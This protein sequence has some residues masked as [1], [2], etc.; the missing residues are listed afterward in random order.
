MPAKRLGDEFGY[1]LV[2]VL[3]S[4]VIMVLAI[5][6]MMAMFDT[7]FRSATTGSNYDTARMLANLKLEQAKNLPFVDVESNFPQAG[8]ATPYDDAAWLTEPGADFTNF[9]YR[10]EKDYMVQP[11]VDPDTGA[12]DPDCNPSGDFFETSGTPTGLIRV[13]VTVGWEGVDDGTPDKTFTTS[14]LVAQ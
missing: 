6:P 4:I 8:N 1:S 14:G 10:V 2:E 3:V 7:G 11:C 5:L 9:R 12:H 13:T